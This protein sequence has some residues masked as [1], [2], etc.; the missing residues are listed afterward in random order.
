MKFFANLF[1]PIVL[2]LVFGLLP[3]TNVAA[4]GNDCCKK[5]TKKAAQKSSEC[6]QKGAN[7]D[8]PCEKNNDCGGDCQGNSCQCAPIIIFISP[9]NEVGWVD[10]KPTYFVISTKA[11]WYFLQKIP[12]DVFLSIFLPPKL[13]C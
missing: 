9:K 12:T 3:T 2:M 8:A 1:L 13:V 7:K 6:C 4:C 10:L 11:N 5:E